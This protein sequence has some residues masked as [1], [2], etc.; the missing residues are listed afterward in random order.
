MKKFYFTFLAALFMLIGCGED[1]AP[2]D[3]EQEALVVKD[4]IPTIKGD[5]IFLA[6]AAVIKG[7]DFIYGVE[8]DSISRQLADS[9]AHFKRDEFDM[10][11]VTVKAKILQNP[12]QQGWEE[13]VQIKEILEISARV[14]DTA[15]AP[16]VKKD[17]DKP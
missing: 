1:S 2:E 10:V 6:D 8:M 5:F 9:V 13:L 12:G 17:I 3:V 14:P 15:S 7:K 4:S 11:P 16:K